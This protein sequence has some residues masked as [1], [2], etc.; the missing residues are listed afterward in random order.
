MKNWTTQAEQRLTEYLQER[1]AREGFD[2][3]DAVELKDDLRRHIH[4]E[5]EQAPSADIGLLH[6][7]N[8]L[9]RLDAGYRPAP[10]P[11]LV[12]PEPNKSSG[13]LRWT[14]GVVLP[15]AVLILE[16]FTSL[17]GAVFF[18]PIPTWWHAA[19]IATVPLVNAWLLGGG[20]KAGDKT[21][22]AA[23]GFM[24]VTA[25]FYGVLFLPLLPLSLIA[26]IVYGLGIISLTPV[27]AAFYSWRIG[28][29]A[30]QNSARP[31]HFKTGWRIG[32]LASVSVLVALEIPAIWTRVNLATA[33][34][35]SAESVPAIARLRAL[36]SEETLLRACYEGNRG[37]AMSTDISG[38]ILSGWNISAGIFG[39]QA[40]LRFDSAKARDLYFRITGKSFNS[41][42][43]PGSSGNSLIGRRDT[44]QEFEFDDHLGG[45]HV[46]VRLK[47][48][49][50]AESRFDGHVDSVSR[51]GYGEWTMVFKNG[52][53]QAKEARCQVKL[54]RDGRVSRLTLWVNGEPREAAFSTVSKVK[55]AYKA[56]AVVQRRDPVLVNMVGPDTVMVQCFPVPAHGE[57]KIR[58][59]VTAP[60]DGIR[61]EMPHVVERNFGIKEDLEHAVWWQGDRAFD[62]TGTGTPMN[63]ARDGDG[64]SLAATLGGTS[65]MTAGF[66][67]NTAPLPAEPAVV[68]CEDR[69][70]KPEERFLVREPV[71]IT[72][73]PAGQVVVVIDGSLS[74]AGAQDW[75]T[76][77][78]GSQD[79]GKFQ[80]I[81]ADDHARRVTLDE[82]KQYRFSGGRNNEPALREGIRLSKESGSPVVWIHGPQAVGLSQPEALLQLLERGTVPPVIHEVEA[83]AG[84]NRLSEAIYRS[85]C[86]HRGPALVSPEKDF[87]RF[88]KELRTER[89][90]LS[91][92][93][94]RAAAADGLTGNRVWDQLARL[95]A[96]ASAED[97]KNNLTD[98]ARS[99]LAARYQL[100]T[101][102]S[103]AV[104]LETQQQYDEHGLTPADGDATPKIPSVPEP[105]TGLLVILTTAAALMRRKRV[106]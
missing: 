25:L 89:R 67:L 33:M 28:R 80:L 17:C 35:D 65:F 24:L 22:G 27:L 62:L 47:N 8:I 48:L 68:W 64:H 37:V 63:A 3:E 45:D 54:P 104:V 49:D 53:A 105:S 2:G 6:L 42:K 29:T 88:L 84:P 85:G 21:R 39:E 12:S 69:F 59:G 78:L 103:G 71:A 36:H 1:A 9:G 94:K 46:A 40:S 31:D 77:S 95:W 57:M 82:L 52:S 81:L 102:I 72:H 60:L 93:W 11:E 97:P 56:V 92:N 101:P 86:L 91:W 74:L 51:I 79:E 19:W 99:E 26:L 61:W 43:P 83:V 13:I 50:L 55:A 16:M 34:E 10:R 5:A 98:A 18:S 87:T 76:K 106:A 30:R 20:Q 58:F 38:W 96:A 70:A 100:V 41:M 66:A 23:A 4:E 75:I 73:P 90:E 15:A 32:V 44:L 7:E 14:F